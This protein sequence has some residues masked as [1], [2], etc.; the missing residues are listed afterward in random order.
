[1]PATFEHADLSGAR[2]HRADLTGA[3]F[4]QVNFYKVVMRGAEF[5]DTDIDGEI[6]G[7]RV[8][9][10]EVAPLVEAELDRRDPDRVKMRPTDPAGFREAWELLGRL[11]DGTVARARRLDPALLHESVDGEWSFIQTLRHLAYATDTWVLRVM[12]GDPDPYDP[13]DLP[14]DQLPEP[15]PA[16]LAGRDARPSLDEVLAL[17]R[18]RRARVRAVLD[19]LTDERLAG[20]TEPVEGVGWPWP[21]AYP[22]RECL[23]TV[24]N[25]EWQ[26]RLYAERDLTALAEVRS[27]SRP[28]SR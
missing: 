3:R 19:D 27:G 23:L 13:L 28:P 4:D 2:F 21:E 15:W 7:L 17:R 22:V 26:H 6:S 8:N 14:F 11:W 25:E 20:R 12:Q 24:L 16:G 5:Y 1:M 10:V 18:D 9:G